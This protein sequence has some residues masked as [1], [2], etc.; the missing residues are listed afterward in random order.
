MRSPHK[1]LRLRSLT[2]PA[3]LLISATLAS[4]TPAAQEEASSSPASESSIES[5]LE[6]VR[7]RRDKLQKELEPQV[8]VI[9]QEL[10]KTGGRNAGAERRL[11][12]Q[13]GELGPEALPLF[14]PYLDPGLP[15]SR[16][17]SYRARTLTGILRKASSDSLSSGLIQL[18]Q[19]ATAEGKRNAV[20]VLA[21][22]PKDTRVDDHLEELFD[23]TE[24]DLRLECL[25]ALGARGGHRELLAETL[26]DTDPEILAIALLAL[27]ERAE[28]SVA[29]KVRALLDRPRAS[30]QVL[31]EL[32]T[33][34]LACPAMVDEETLNPLLA[35]LL[36]EE[37]DPLSRIKLLDAVPSFAKSLN[38]KQRR[39]IEPILESPKSELREAGL[40]CMTLVG[41][42]SARKTLLK[43]YSRKVDN[44]RGSPKPYEERGDIYMRIGE[45]V[46]ASKD[47]KRSIDVLAERASLATY[48]GLW[49]K[50]SKS[51]VF[52]SKLRQAYDTLKEFG[53]GPELRREILA[54]PDFKPLIESRY[55]REFR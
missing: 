22:Q 28:E 30:S 15:Q 36:K 19:S 52:S 14:L 51:Y 55:G 23:A 20:T 37:I 32:T 40:V 9:V 50:L 16:G 33:Y 17:P 6:R 1:P 25:R 12:R 18:T 2:I 7:K 46:P 47:Y 49:I 26:K 39:L 34:Y 21:S 8:E 29:P 3:A 11:T 24:G 35:L 45:P 54:D 53:L 4:S 13:I 38:L 44:R 48:R 10:E 31:D 41:Q 42:R 5:L 27:A 43:E